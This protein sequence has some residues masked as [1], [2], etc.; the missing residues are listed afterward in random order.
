M[1][2]TGNSS[3]HSGVMTLISRTKF[4]NASLRHANIVP[5]RIQLVT[6]RCEG[7]VHYVI[8]V[9]QKVLGST[10][11]CTEQRNQVWEALRKTIAQCPSQHSLIVAG[12][13]NTGLRQRS[14]QTGS[15]IV[16]SGNAVSAPDQVRFQQMLAQFDLRAL[17]TFRPGPGKHTFQT[18][19]TGGSLSQ[20]DYILIRGSRTDNRA[21]AVQ[22]I[23]NA[24]V[25]AW[26]GGSRH[27][28]I[29]AN[30]AIK[31]FYGKPPTPHASKICQQVIKGEAIIRDEVGFRRRVDEQIAQLQVWSTQ[32]VNDILMEATK[33]FAE[34]KCSPHRRSAIQTEQPVKRMW[35]C[36]R[37]IQQLK[38][39]PEHGEREARISS[40]QTEFRAIQKEL[41]QASKMRK[42]A[43]VETCI[44]QA[45]RAQEVGDIR[46][47]HLQINKIAPKAKRSRRQLRDDQGALMTPEQEA[48]V[49]RAHWQGVY[50]C[51][52][53]TIEPNICTLQIPHGA[54]ATELS[55][56]P[57]YKALPK[58]YAP[59]L[60]WRLGAQSIAELAEKTILE[61]WR[62]TQVSIPRAWLSLLLKPGKSGKKPGEYRPIG[63]TDPIGKSV[64]GAI[65][66][67]HN[68]IWYQEASRLPQFA[69]TE[70]RGTAQARVEPFIT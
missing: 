52:G 50:D 10:R 20:I 24:P 14:P 18:T 42:T 68:S 34:P 4:P 46:M 21:K 30:I 5:G 13:F 60:A 32:S 35:H 70:M 3:H 62:A 64:L 57:E 58:H 15:A 29:L 66:K 41:R 56:L 38:Q 23:R 33:Q 67:E 31:C 25:G 45:L 6:V 27:F 26:R 11:T 2:S 47:L 61:E 69:Y 48:E 40:L 19:P 17:N 49:I 65:A 51:T 22:I 9:Y 8:N 55:K 37:Q 59:S 44:T 39:Q 53:S 43:F 63:L 36:H 12:D 1:L 16:Q 54:L 7:Q 28:P